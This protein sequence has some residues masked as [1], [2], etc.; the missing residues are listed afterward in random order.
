VVILLS[1]AFYVI[2]GKIL[3]IVSLIV[4]VILIV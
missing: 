4:D 2:F 1:V 3:L